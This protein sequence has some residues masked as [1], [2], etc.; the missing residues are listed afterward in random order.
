LT[1]AIELL[2][3]NIAPI[4]L[5]AAIGGLLQR[6]FDLDPLPLSRTIFYG[7]GPALVFKSIVETTISPEDIGRMGLFGLLLPVIMGAFT[8]AV[9][10]LLKFHAHTTSALVISIMF[11][12]AGNYGLPL[13]GFAF[14]DEGLAWA[15]IF[16]IVHALLLNSIA[17]VIASAGREP[18]GK[19]FLHMFQVPA[20]YAI[21]LAFLARSFSF[22]LPLYAQ[23]SI[24]LLAE[25]AIPCMLF[26]LGMQIVRAGWPKQWGLIGLIALLRLVISPLLGFPLANLVGLNGLGLSAGVTEAAMPS[27]VMATVLSTEYNLE[28]DLVTG[29]VLITTLLSPITLTI[30][31]TVLGT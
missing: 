6:A 14:G 16:F 28:S 29:A 21:P 18:I 27:A 1:A 31:L 20:V 7:F 9:A 15:T 2:A 25:A 11:L 5:V 26:L 22:E 3:S 24:D 30:V 8:F 17:V 12:N 19:A 10:R 13:I 4:I 23:R